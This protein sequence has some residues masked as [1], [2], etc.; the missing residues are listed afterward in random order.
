ME[1]HCQWEV[2][3]GNGYQ[4]MG[5]VLRLNPHIYFLGVFASLILV[6]LHWNSMFIVICGRVGLLW[7]CPPC[8][9]NYFWIGCR[10]NSICIGEGLS[11]KWTPKCVCV[12]ACVYCA[13]TRLNRL[14]IFSCIVILYPL[15]GMKC[16]IGLLWFKIFPQVR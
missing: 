16:P 11:L 4:R 1:L 15:F 2:T 7:K 9:G 10:W 14:Y 3:L 6:N 13:G 5:G 12:C 8:H